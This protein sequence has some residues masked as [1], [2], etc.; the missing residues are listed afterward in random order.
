MLSCKNNKNKK[1]TE[2]N[3]VSSEKYLNIKDEVIV[4]DS[5]AFVDVVYKDSIKDWKGYF[6][7]AKDLDFLKKTTPNE[8][9]SASDELVKDV[10]L[11]RDSITVQ[12]LNE[13]GIK[14]RLNALYN[15]SLRLKEMKSI[16][17]IKVSEIIDETKGLFSIYRMI[18]HKINALYEQVNFE[19]DLKEENFFFSKIDSIK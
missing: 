9:L 11:M 10:T 5:L 6:K 7:V 19:K 8:V 2:K 12:T 3:E 18:N 1:E 15:Q 13:K 14:A 16:P 4:F 17:A